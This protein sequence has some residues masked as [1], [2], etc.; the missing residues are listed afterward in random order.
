M[1][2]QGF[3]NYRIQADQDLTYTRSTIMKFITDETTD[4]S[5]SLP[6]S[7]S[8]AAGHS[9]K[10]FATFILAMALTSVVGCASH[11]AKEGNKEASEDVTITNKVV[12]AINDEPTLKSA[13]INV[14]TSKGVVLLTGV[15]S[16]AAAE[17]TATEL[18]RY[19]KG[20]TL[21]RDAIQIK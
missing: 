4:H 15:V 3:S 10:R 9:N 8:H 1:D 6:Q 2:R 12:K 5:A 11:A 7:I 16:S 14:E 19:I 20:V 18:A 13:V 21:V 17:N